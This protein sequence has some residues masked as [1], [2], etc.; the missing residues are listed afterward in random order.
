[1]SATKYCSLTTGLLD[2]A[3]SYGVRRNAGMGSDGF[4]SE[5]IGY[6]QH[7]WS[8]PDDVSSITA[9][10]T[11]RGSDQHPARDL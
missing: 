3:C 6:A 2:P 9:T 4:A 1:V 11:Q 5:G 7:R 10:S 8:P